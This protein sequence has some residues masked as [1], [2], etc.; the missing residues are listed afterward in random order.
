MIRR[1]PRSTRPDTLFPYT[2]LFRSCRAPSLAAAENR[3]C[4]IAERDREQHRGQPIEKAV[5]LRRERDETLE[6]RLA[7]LDI[8]RGDRDHAPLADQIGFGAIIAD[9]HARGH[10]NARAIENATGDRRTVE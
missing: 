10:R 7:D 9:R 2:T 3:R 4:G 5:P 1:P 8:A 6:P